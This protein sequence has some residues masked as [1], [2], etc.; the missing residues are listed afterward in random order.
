MSS[1]GL[2]P[3]VSLRRRA[4]SAGMWN[5]GALIASQVIRLGGNLIIS[6]LLVPEMFG[7]MAITT[8]VSVL[9][10][11]FSDVGLRQNIVQSPRGDDP[12]F[13]N[14]A[15]TVQIL[16][17]SVLFVLT[18]VLA[19]LAWGSQAIELWPAN[20]TYAAPELPLVLAVTGI[21]AIISG[22][23]STKGDL[24]VRTFQQKKAV[25]IDLASQLAGLV[26]M[27]VLG[28]LTRSIWSLVAAGLIGNL[29]Y[30]ILSHL[31]FQ[32]PD[33][34]L[35]WDR[36]ALQ[37][38]VA[39]GRWI[40]LSSAV[41]VLA[42]YGDRIWFGGSMTARELG[43]YSIAALLV[44]ALQTALLRL[45]SAVAFPAFCE[46]AR[47][48]DKV[49]LQ[50]LY[51]RFRL[52]FD[53]TLLFGCGLLL[54]ISPL[55]IGWLYDARY[56]EAGRTLAILSLSFFVLRYTLAHQVWLALGLTKYQAIDNIIRVVSLWTLLPL[57]LAIGGADY[58]IWGVALHTL[59]TLVL[60]V[61]VNR[62]L[63]IFS[64][65]RELVVLP[66]LG[67]GVLCGEL[68]MGLAKWL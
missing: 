43:V 58:A 52:L 56:A 1:I 54:V 4:M 8:T 41:G 37:E 60:I 13:L 27:L 64:L 61:Y 23:Q 6:R 3:S 5:I 19:L 47:S 2:S 49:R 45:V 42:M 26:V 44:G 11:L 25:L 48:D 65:K 9:L 35:Q 38:L 34:R 15:W 62:Q 28:Y 30:V 31:L 55:L 51:Y 18:L 17:G 7:I 59:P 46:A 20:S 36:S 63:G 12:V 16:R 33:N 22:F 32:G 39:Y 50:A 21:G 66:M 53:V 24:A 67:V 10:H 40:L 14:T 57:S 68:V 29:A